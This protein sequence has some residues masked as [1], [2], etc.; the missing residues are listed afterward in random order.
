[1]DGSI[2]SRIINVES[3]TLT[4]FPG[5]EPKGGKYF[6]VGDIDGN[7][8]GSC[9]VWPAEG[10]FHEF[11]GG[12]GGDV[13]DILCHRLN[14]DVAGVARWLEDNGWMDKDT[15]RRPPPAPP[16]AESPTLRILDLAPP[17][18]A[19]P[20]E[21]ALLAAYRSNP[22]GNPLPIIEGVA[23]PVHT[24]CSARGDGVLLVVRYPV[25]RKDGQPDKAVRRWSWSSRSK[26]WR[27]GGTTN[28][29]LPLYRLPALAASAESQPVLIVEG[30][31]TAAAAA[32][33]ALFDRYVTTC[34]VGGSSPAPGTDWK[35][36][37]GHPVY[38]LPDADLPGN[39]SRAFPRK[40][41]G[42]TLKAGASSTQIVNPQL[43]YERLGGSGTPDAGWDVADAEH[44]CP[45][46]NLDELTMT[47][48][49]WRRSG[50]LSPSI[51]GPREED[52]PPSSADLLEEKMAGILARVSAGEY[53][54]AVISNCSDC[55]GPTATARAQRCPDCASRLLG[56]S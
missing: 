49:E 26:R 7:P 50:R 52:Q 31:R 42:A 48:E 8:G 23:I 18:A 45:P 1:M 15:I 25:R 47:L 17:G 19:L 37:A 34:A 21:R 16:P 6:Q 30:E 35:P 56:A 36:V 3:L 5:K 44:D 10:R 39:P 51:P 54:H 40:V 14:T 11:N 29:M 41:I 38:V 28:A 53:G 33:M 13:V 20:T 4:L 2:L 24:Y 55:G 32:E 12:V 43:V 9:T 46:I 27:A 22:E